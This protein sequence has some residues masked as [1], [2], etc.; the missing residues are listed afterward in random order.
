VKLERDVAPPQ[1]RPA[2]RTPDVARITFQLFAIGVL[3][4]AT[5]WILRPFLIPATWAITIVVAT[6]P[7]PTWIER[8]LGGHRGLAAAAMTVALML[9]FAAPLSFT[10]V[11][12]LTSLGHFTEWS[13]WL[14]SIKLPP[15]PAWLEG[16][17]AVGA[18]LAERWRDLAAAGT[19]EVSAFVASY[20]RG[21][22]IALLALI[23]NVGRLLIDMVLTIIIAGILYATGDTAAHGA[24]RFARRLAGRHGESS[25]HLAGQ[26]VRAVA[27][28]VVV[29]AI[30]QSGLAGLG[31]AVAGVPFAA[32]LTVVMFILCVAQIG[33][34]P[35]LIAVVIA[36]FV[37]R[38]VAWGTGL[39]IWAIVCSVLDNILR[40]VLIK[41]GADLPLLLI[42]AGVVGGLIA[43]GVIGLFI[44]PVVLAVAHALT[45]AWV[46]V[47]RGAG[48]GPLGPAN[49]G[50]RGM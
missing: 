30:V 13:Q 8:R 17:P 49:V 27:L 35:V 46:D 4:A 47:E 2:E 18:K 20:A 33:P 26:A 12:L 5:F 25:V 36:V 28:G 44:G 16:I 23:G 11:T 37:K 21:L 43:F 41:R 14:A 40:P 10:V 24:Q 15:P 39:L 1:L 48:D 22:T 19:E 34:A 32:I 9:V 7:L 3:I 45:V 31:L 50:D 29:T 6:W 42:F 38:G